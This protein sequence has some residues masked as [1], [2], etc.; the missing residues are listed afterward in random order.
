L[1]AV[2]PSRRMAIDITTKVYGRRR[3]NLTI[4]IQ[5]SGFVIVKM[6]KERQRLLALSSHSKQGSGIRGQISSAT[7]YDI[8]YLIDPRWRTHSCVPR[9]HSCERLRLE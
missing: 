4:H 3:A 8:G 7:S 5:N 1:I 9:S 6:F 2:I